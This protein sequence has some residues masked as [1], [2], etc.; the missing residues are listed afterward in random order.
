[1]LQHSAD[2]STDQSALQQALGSSSRI[3]ADASKS[4]PLS[5]R[6]IIHDLKPLRS[7]QSKSTGD[8]IA[9]NAEPRGK[10]VLNG[11]AMFA[12]K[13]VTATTPATDSHAAA[14]AMP[15]GP[16]AARP[17]QIT[18]AAPAEALTIGITLRA[19]SAPRHPPSGLWPTGQRTSTP[20]ASSIRPLGV[21]GR[22]LPMQRPVGST[23]FPGLPPTYPCGIGCCSRGGVVLGASRWCWSWVCRRRC[24]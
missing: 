4:Q 13:A 24:R 10:P 7:Q 12:T 9:S 3:S 21:Q 23:P 1:M 20:V 11:L 15:G 17:A 8:I 18:T 5:K 16:V 22:S 6:D 2:E 19:V 14:P